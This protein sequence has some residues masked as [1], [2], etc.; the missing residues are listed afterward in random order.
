MSPLLNGSPKFNVVQYRLTALYTVELFK[1]GP[2][3][4]KTRAIR[5]SQAE[6][7]K[8]EEFLASNPIFDFSTLARAAILAFIE[9][10][11]LKLTAIS[12]SKKQKPESR[13]YG[14]S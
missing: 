5:F 9:E 8:I 6:D 13:A 3:M 11:K 10:P 4:S 14:Q 12:K 1:L 7:K 2:A